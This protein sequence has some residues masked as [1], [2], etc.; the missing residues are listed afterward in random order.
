MLLGAALGEA[1]VARRGRRAIVAEPQLGLVEV[2]VA[3]APP[4]AGA[5]AAGRERHAL[6]VGRRRGEELAGVAVGADGHRRAAVAPHA[7][8][9]VHP[10]DVAAG[11]REV[12]PLAVARPPVQPLQ[13]IVERHLFE[14]AGR[15]REDVDVAA[16]G[17]IRNERQPLA[18]RRIERPRLGRLVRDEQARIAAGGRHGPDVAARDHRD[19]GAIRG[20][21]RFGKRRQRFDSGHRGRLRRLGACRHRPGAPCGNE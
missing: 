12:Q 19:L 1:L 20:D 16:A 15:K 5:V 7:I 18:V 11:R 4:L 21:R 3:L 17:A 6:A 8:E 9:V 2:R 10:R 13:P 14:G